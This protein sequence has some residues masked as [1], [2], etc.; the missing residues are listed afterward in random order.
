MAAA[1]WAPRTTFPTCVESDM[2]VNQDQPT[3]MGGVRASL[4]ARIGRADE[5]LGMVAAFLLPLGVCLIGLGWY[6]AAHTPYA[7]EQLPYLIS[8]GL[9]GLALATGGGLAYVGSWV[10]RSAAQQAAANAELMVVLGELRE[11][12]RSRPSAARPAARR[13]GAVPS[14]NAVPMSGAVPMQ[15]ASLVATANGSMLHRPECTVV[16][17]RLDLR[18]MPVEGSG[19]KAC[20]LCQP[21]GGPARRPRSVAGQR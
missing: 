17:G 7:F 3:A 19:L 6:G 13:A 9:V 12:L 1:P 11:D 21:L 8:G 16:R 20:G 15:G 18:D 14:S 4:R 10:A 5:L 2:T